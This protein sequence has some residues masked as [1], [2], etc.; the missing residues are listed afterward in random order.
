[1]A[2]DGLC[3]AG[4][5][6]PEPVIAEG[7]RGHRFH[8][9]QHQV[10]E[11][12]GHELP[13]R[14]EQDDLR[15]S[16]VVVLVHARPSG[17][18]PARRPGQTAARGEPGPLPE[19]RQRVGAVAHASRPGIVA[20]GEG[21]RSRAIALFEEGLTSRRWPGSPWHRTGRSARHDCWGRSSSFCRPSA[22]HSRPSSG[23][24]TTGSSRQFVTHWEARASRK[25]TDGAPR[26]RWIRPS[27][28]R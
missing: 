8:T 7:E 21:D 6:A 22:G 10:A 5:W 11:R 9:A 4:P 2:S 12:A 16:R 27:R 19:P 28:T 18:R 23:R 25:P 15:G 1:M 13:V 20:K 14:L 26:W 3:P 17:R 24:L